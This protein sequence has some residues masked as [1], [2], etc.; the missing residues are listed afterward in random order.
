M[1]LGSDWLRLQSPD[2]PDAGDSVLNER[3]E[4]N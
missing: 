1:H 4:I 3:Q 2:N